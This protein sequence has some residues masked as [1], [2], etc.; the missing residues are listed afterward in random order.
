MK[1]EIFKTDWGWMGIGAT[2]RGVATIILPKELVGQL[3]VS[4][5]GS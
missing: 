2:P 4:C 5:S 1:V 3:R